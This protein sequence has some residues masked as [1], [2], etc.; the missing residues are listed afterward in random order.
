VEKGCGVWLKRGSENQICL[1]FTGSLYKEAMGAAAILAQWGIEADLYNLRFLKPV[2]E[3]YLCQIMN[4][5]SLV[6]FIEEGVRDGGFA[7]FASSLARKYNCAAR[8]ET[9]AIEGDYTAK[10]RALG[11]RDELIAMNGLDDKRIAI[12]V[13]A[14]YS[15]Q[16][17][18]AENS[19][20]V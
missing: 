6:V 12:Q 14:R 2:D 13:K 18:I 11:A 4:A 8:V 16:T 5:Y 7:E 9:M 1:A 15:A 10:N 19:K 3:N 20:K 17:I